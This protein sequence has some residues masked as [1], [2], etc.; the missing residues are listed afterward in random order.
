MTTA[1]DPALAGGGEHGVQVGRL[2]GGPHAVDHQVAEAGLHGAD[3]PGACARRRAAPTRSGTRWRSCRRCRSRRS[4][5]GRRSGRRRRPRPARRAPPAGRRPPARAGRLPGGQLRAGRVGEQRHRAG[6]GGAG[7]EL[8]AVPAGAGQRRVQVAGADL[9]AGVGH[10]GDDHLGGVRRQARRRAGRRDRRAGRPVTVRG[11]WIAGHGV[12]PYPVVRFRPHSRPGGSSALT[13]DVPPSL[14]S[15]E[16]P[17]TWAA[18]SAGRRRHPVVAQGEAP[19]CRGTPARRRR[20]PRRPGAYTKTAITYRG[21]S[22]G[23]M[24]MNEADLAG[25][26][27]LPL[28]SRQPV[29]V[30]PA[31][32]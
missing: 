5:S 24:P 27:F 12:R 19:S 31:T 6:L 20:R 1:V 14:L 9:L 10:P 2:R 28:T 30:L 18:R 7:G 17:R 32:R 3:Q 23:A 13:D 26:T 21:F 25:L 15:A 29:P 22:A 4:R 16:R 11:T 8:R